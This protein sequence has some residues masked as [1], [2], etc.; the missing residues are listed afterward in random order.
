MKLGLFDI[1]S[2]LLNGSGRA[3]E[4]SKRWRKDRT[5]PLNPIREDF[6]TLLQSHRSSNKK[7]SSSLFFFRR[8]HHLQD[9]SWLLTLRTTHISLPLR[10]ELPNLKTMR[11]AFSSRSQ[12]RPT[13]HKMG[14]VLG[15]LKSTSDSPPP[16]PPPVP[17]P[18]PVN[19]CPE[20]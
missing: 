9:L 6:F 15:T 18:S 10:A 5:F 13:A 11:L 16:P 3:S 14:R 20:N 12:Q 8:A 2:S 4:D 19:R 17:P 1:V 7:P